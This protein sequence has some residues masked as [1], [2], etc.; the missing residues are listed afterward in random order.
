MGHV[1]R[2]RLSNADAQALRE[3]L[4][5]VERQRKVG[6]LRDRKDAVAEDTVL[7]DQRFE[8]VPEG[9]ALLAVLTRG[10]A[11]ILGVGT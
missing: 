6:V 3:D 9:P 4:V 2:R 1:R 11:R 8:I 10:L 5:L 7:A